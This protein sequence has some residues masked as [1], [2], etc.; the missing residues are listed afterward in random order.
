[1][2]Y[3][4]IAKG[5]EFTDRLK[6]EVEAR[7]G[8]LERHL[9]N[10]QPSVFHASVAVER[11]ARGGQYNA[12]LAL[13]VLK[14]ILVARRPGPTAEA[15]V[16]RASVEVERQVERYKSRLRQDYLYKRKRTGLSGRQSQALERELLK[17]R[18]LLDRAITGDQKAVRELTERELPALTRYIQRSLDRR[19]METSVIETQV[20]IVIERALQSGFENLPRKPE[21]MTLQGWLAQYARQAIKHVTSNKG[22]R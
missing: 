11:P 1:M 12:R 3:H 18:V 4:C 5:F 8:H 15:A 16:D 9:R 22:L 2:E 6:K 10:F 20:P 17:D 14:R 13:N 7:L 19:G 21:K